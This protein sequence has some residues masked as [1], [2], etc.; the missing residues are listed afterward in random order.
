[1]KNGGKITQ[2]NYS[3]QVEINLYI[4]YEQID[5]FTKKYSN[6][7]FDIIKCEILEEK[8]ADISTK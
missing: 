5:K 4:P 6:I 8:I 1:M 7:P 3:E 2:I